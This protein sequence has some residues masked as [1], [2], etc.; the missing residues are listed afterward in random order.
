MFQTIN[1]SLKDWENRP[2]G[3]IIARNLGDFT[4]E[5]LNHIT[6]LPQQ[7]IF[8]DDFFQKVDSPPIYAKF[9]GKVVINQWIDGYLG[10][11]PSPVRMVI[12]HGICGHLVGYQHHQHHQHRK[13]H[14]FHQ[15]NPWWIS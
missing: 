1:Q 15:R 13:K 12:F 4:E 14:G 8:V 2:I 7:L 3:E 9:V 5:S 10:C 6:F 11:G